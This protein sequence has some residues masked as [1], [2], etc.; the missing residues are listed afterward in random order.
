MVTAPIPARYG[1]C[2]LREIGEGTLRTWLTRAGM[3]AERLHGV[4][5]QELIFCYIQQD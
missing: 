3:H 1:F 2:I 4:F 5:F